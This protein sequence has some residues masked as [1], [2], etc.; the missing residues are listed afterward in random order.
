MEVMP[1]GCTGP[2][3]C[4]CKD[5]KETEDEDDGEM[6]SYESIEESG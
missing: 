6:D 1:R 4:P 3:W 5:Y 2:P